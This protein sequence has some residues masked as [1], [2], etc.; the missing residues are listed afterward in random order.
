MGKTLEEI[1][2]SLG[3]SYEGDG[4]TPI[5]GVAGIREAK[6]GDMTFLANPKYHKELAGTSASA[7]VAA[8]GVDTGGLAVIRADNP[9]YAFSLVVRMFAPD[10]EIVPGIHPGAVVGEGAVIG[11]GA[12]VYPNAFVEKGARIG[13][14]TV[15]Y[16]GVYIGEGSS[17]GEDCII[18]P[19]VV[20]R[21]GVRIGDR[22]IIHGG[23]VVGADGFGYATEKGVH[24]K[25]PQIGGVVIEDDVELGAN[26]TVDR[27]A[28][29]DTVIKRG[30]KIDNLVMIAHNVVI[31]EGSIIVAQAG[32]SGS[33]VLGHHVVLAGQVGLV[34][35]LNIGDGVQ[36]GAKSGVSRDLDAWQAYSGI[37]AIP[38]KEWLRVQA[39]LP[40][41]PELKKQLAELIRQVEELKNRNS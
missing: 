15:I 19:N 40:R 9:Y 14:H 11:E 25:I 7:V 26:V 8:P 3:C 6:K 13:A 18:Y 35:H 31:G 1:A 17:V 29:G 34:G 22:V 4:S 24:H 37:P 10:R 27:G 39:V 23:T 32:I 36:V 28:L 21:D 30:S 38:H 16:P 33:T 41:L 12:S 20:I 5:K 2:S